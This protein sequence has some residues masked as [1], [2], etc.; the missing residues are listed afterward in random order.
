MLRNGCSGETQPRSAGTIA[1]VAVRN[2][3]SRKSLTTA[4]EVQDTP[5]SLRSLV[6]CKAA[7]LESLQRCPR[8]HDRPEVEE[9]W[10]H[11]T[12]VTIQQPITPNHYSEEGSPWVNALCSAPTVPWDVTSNNTNVLRIFVLDTEHLSFISSGDDAERSAFRF[13]TQVAG[14]CN[15]GHLWRTT[16]SLEQKRC[17]LEYLKTM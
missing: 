15:Q 1:L 9:R 14:N 2:I 17:L 11:D 4:N 3:V 6:G 7:W 5:A 12:A 13:D 8:F 10:R 16:L